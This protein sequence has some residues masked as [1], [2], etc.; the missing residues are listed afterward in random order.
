M[1]DDKIRNAFYDLVSENFG[2]WDGERYVKVLPAEI[3]EAPSDDTF[4]FKAVEGEVTWVE[5]LP[6]IP[7]IPS[8]DTFVFK[9]VEGEAA[10]VEDIPEIPE[11]PSEGAF[12]LKA[13]N[14]T[15]TWV[16]EETEEGTG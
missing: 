10:W 14:G 16:E 7:E 1:A 4:V 9:A 13:V 12:V 3:P 6:E 8:D 5:D 11:V 15:L 2:Y